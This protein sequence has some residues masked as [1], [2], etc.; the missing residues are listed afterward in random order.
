MGRKHPFLEPQQDE[1]SEERRRL[2]ERAEQEGREESTARRRERKNPWRAEE[3]TSRRLGK[4]EAKAREWADPSPNPTLRASWVL[5]A[6]DGSCVQYL[7]L[8]WGWGV[9]KV[10]PRLI[11]GP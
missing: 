8:W 4:S 5:A 6:A 1:S 7:G 11:C 2:G 3:A 9:P 10:A